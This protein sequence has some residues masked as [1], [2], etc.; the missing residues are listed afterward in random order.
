ML[1]GILASALGVAA[2]VLT[3][4]ALVPA[5]GFGQPEAV[6]STHQGDDPAATDHPAQIRE[7]RQQVERLEGQINKLSKEKASLL[8]DKTRA[9]GDL[10]RNANENRGKL[11]KLQSQLDKAQDELK[12][13]L[14][15]HAGEIKSNKDD[16]KALE[17]ER[18]QLHKWME[19]SEEK[20]VRSIGELRLAEGERI[21]KL[22]MKTLKNLEGK[23]TLTSPGW[24]YRLSVNYLDDEKPKDEN[25]KGKT[26]EGKKKVRRLE[27]VADGKPI[28][29]MLDDIVRL[30]SVEV[31]END[32]L[33][34]KWDIVDKR[35]TS[36]LQVQKDLKVVLPNQLLEVT[37]NITEAERPYLVSL[38]ERSQEKVEKNSLSIKDLEDLA[39]ARITLDEPKTTADLRTHLWEPVL[40]KG[41]ITLRPLSGARLF[42]T[43][44]DRLV[45]IHR[46]P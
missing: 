4:F 17:Q 30:A 21:I 1:S 14:S 27:I 40:A 8:E 5:A 12:D 10:D 36:F 43:I 11:S 32:Q 2:M 22:S 39:N 9:I 31:V 34:L 38:R 6:R 7:L 16:I 24:G 46:Q 26:E 13:A 15:K 42:M 35:K 33:K 37:T 18:G 41:A 29:S 20:V 19:F 3:G 45:E 23:H 44:D 28:G 25:K